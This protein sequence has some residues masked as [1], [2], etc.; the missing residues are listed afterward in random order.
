MDEWTAKMGMSAGNTMSRRG[1]KRD[2]WRLFYKEAK[3]M[4]LQM[5]EG[6]KKTGKENLNSHSLL[7]T[8]GALHLK[9]GIT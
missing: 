9:S 2:G 4:A 8:G 7:T 1:G 3:D 6:C 5:G